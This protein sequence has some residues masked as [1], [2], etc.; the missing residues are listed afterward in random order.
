[1]VD[2]I[3]QLLEKALGEFEGKAATPAGKH[4]F[5]VHEDSENL[6]E[7]LSILFHNLV[8]KSLF[9]CKRSRPYI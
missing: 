1:M 8:A 2:Y 6:E 5:Y 4:L 3:K 7:D 9:P